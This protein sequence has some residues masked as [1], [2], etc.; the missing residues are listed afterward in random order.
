[1]STAKPSARARQNSR[2]YFLAFCCLLAFLSAALLLATVANAA[3]FAPA[4]GGTLTV[5]SS[6]DNVISDTVLTLRE[7]LLIARGGTGGDGVTTGLARKLSVAER[8]QTS[9]CTFASLSDNTITG[10]CGGNQ[11]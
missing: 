1:M 3:Q 9:G 6:A 4:A 5:N 2:A 10:G 7:A 11:P 8:A